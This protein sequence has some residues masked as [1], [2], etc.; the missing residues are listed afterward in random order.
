[1]P[2]L[3][4]PE[5]ETLTIVRAGGKDKYG[6]PLPGTETT[7][8]GCVVWP[9]S[10]TETENHSDTVIVGLAALFP[11]GTDIKATDQV[12]R[13]GDDPKDTS[14]LYSVQGAPGVWDAD[15]GVE[16]ALT[17]GTG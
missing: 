2:W 1:M 9:R 12:R 5:T 13:A 7:V 10:S 3:E 6:N 11:P 8:T 4:F 17:R 14:K 15:T 16:V